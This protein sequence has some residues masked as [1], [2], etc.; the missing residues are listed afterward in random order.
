M[1]GAWGDVPYAVDLRVGEAAFSRVDCPYADFCRRSRELCL[2]AHEQRHS[3]RV[4]V[5]LLAR[6]AVGDRHRRP[7]A[8]DFVEPGLSSSGH[9]VSSAST[10]SEPST[11]PHSAS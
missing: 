2:M 4:E 7:P 9:C 1:P 10:T 8:G 5:N 3:A 6:L 11:S